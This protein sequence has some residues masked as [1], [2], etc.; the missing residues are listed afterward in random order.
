VLAGK[1]IVLG[2]TGGIAAYKAA[3]IVRWLR[4][5][6]AAVV[7]VM[8][9]AAK[10]FITPLTL[11]TLSGSPVLDDLWGPEQ[12]LTFG[13]TRP[14][15]HSK[16]VRCGGDP[17]AVWDGVKNGAEL[18]RRLLEL[19]GI[20][21]MKARTMMG[22]LARASVTSTHRRRSRSIRPRSVRAKRPIA[23]RTRPD[24]ACCNVRP[25]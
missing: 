3:E 24:G 17:T 5:E 21:E 4:K 20:G 23:R 19:P 16:N 7:V 15:F 12:A 22:V 25:E 14:A 9:D 6:D 11:A 8:T 2:V 10:R 18:E 13:R 1:T